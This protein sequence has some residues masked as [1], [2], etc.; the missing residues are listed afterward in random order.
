MY[1]CIHMS[2]GMYFVQTYP[3]VEYARVVD[4]MWHIRGFIGVYM[5]SCRPSM[6]LPVCG[7]RSQGWPF[8]D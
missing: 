3:Y 7:T 4:C 6:L 1:M 8:S 5:E 2:V